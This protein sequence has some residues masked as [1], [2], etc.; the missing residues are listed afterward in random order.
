MV[1]PDS[2]AKFVDHSEVRAVGEKAARHWNSTPSGPGKC[3]GS[4]RPSLLD[5]G[6]AG[7]EASRAD[8]SAGAEAA[9]M[10]WQRPAGRR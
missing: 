6:G 1:F 10:R 8:S 4:T 7:K 9:R 5:S 3:T 2:L